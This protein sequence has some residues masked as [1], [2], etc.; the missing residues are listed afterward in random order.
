MLFAVLDVAA[1]PGTSRPHQRLQF[2][3]PASGDIIGRR[4]GLDAAGMAEACCAGD[5]APM[6]WRVIRR[7]QLARWHESQRGL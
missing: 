2:Q 3:S 7:L 6:S 5:S 4:V 1:R